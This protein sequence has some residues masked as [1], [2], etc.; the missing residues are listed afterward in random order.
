MELNLNKIIGDPDNRTGHFGIKYRGLDCVKCPF[1]YVMY[2]MILNEVKPDL[3]IEIGTWNGGSALYLSD[4]L[5]N[6]NN[7]IVHTIDIQRKEYDSLIRENKGIKIFNEGYENYDI[8]N[9]KDFSKI[10]VIDDGSHQYNDVKSAFSKFS[11][12]VSEDSYYI[13]EDGGIDLYNLDELVKSIF[14]FG[15]PHKA[16]L[17]I[18]QENPDFIIDRK[19]CD[20]FGK[21]TTFNPDGFLRRIKKS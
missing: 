8:S 18:I 3:V 20:F 2:Q 11:K 21:N 15:G 5:R 14:P 9:L 19:W 12:F 17:E 4:I 16:T 13:I 6:L 7:G 1:D 10:L